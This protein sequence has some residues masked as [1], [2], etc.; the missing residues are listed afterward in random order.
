[1]MSLAFV[2]PATSFASTVLS[3]FSPAKSPFYS[4]I[5][6]GT[7]AFILSCE[8]IDQAVWMAVA[9]PIYVVLGLA[10]G[11]SFRARTVFAEGEGEEQLRFAR[12][13]IISSGLLAFVL[14]ARAVNKNGL[15]FWTNYAACLLQ[16][17][18]FLVYWWARSHTAEEQ[19]NVNFVQLALITATFLIGASY[20]SSKYV[21]AL[22]DKDN[23]SNASN[24]FRVAAG[25][26]FWWLV[27][28]GWWLRHL[29]TLIRV[30]IPGVPRQ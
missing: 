14:T 6:F 30:Q 11:L 19:T 18:T 22:T 28:L 15:A 27:C 7:A 17:S 13:F 5:A 23:P 20:A 1:M 4:V 10:L 9:V 24:Y 29:S 2:G 12:S 25:L 3:Y 21:V 16:I 8:Q 26:Y